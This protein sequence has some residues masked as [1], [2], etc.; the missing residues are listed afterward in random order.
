MPVDGNEISRG[1]LIGYLLGELAAE[2]LAAI[3][4]R[5]LRDDAFAEA[6]EA[7]RTDL[8]DEYALGTVS[9]SERERIGRALNLSGEADASLRFARALHRQL[10][11]AGGG[12]Q[13]AWRVRA[14]WAL[15][16]AASVLLVFGAWW[17]WPAAHESRN[18]SALGRETVYTLL[19]RPARLRGAEG[20]RTVQIPAGVT[21]LQVQIELR[22]T[23]PFAEVS[24]Q[25]PGQRLRFRH[26]P[27]RTF[28]GVRFVQFSVPRSALQT[29]RYTLEVRS[30]DATEALRH[31]SLWIVAR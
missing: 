14:R 30:P 26:L 25:G 24:L 16:I 3:D 13:R 22:G 18:G 4:E 12:R 23:G 1:R 11:R 29:G 17:Y 10:D 7:L 21:T 31:Y 15:P 5:V 27:V 6:L 8:L 19:L 20:M 2:E 9:A 28:S